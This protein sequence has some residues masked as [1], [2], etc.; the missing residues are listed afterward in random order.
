M[1]SLILSAVHHQPDI[2]SER[3]YFYY[4]AKYAAAGVESS[5]RP[6]LPGTVTRLMA[7]QNKH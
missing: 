4:M 2:S 6:V 5:T 1:W 7:L 3:L